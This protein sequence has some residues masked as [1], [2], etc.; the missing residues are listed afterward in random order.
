MPKYERVIDTD[1]LVVGGGS[2]GCL[3][4]IRAKE[5][6]PGL[7][8]TV[9]EKGDLMYSGCIARG[10]DALNI[11]A[12]PG[13]TTPELYVES[14]TIACEGVVDEPPSYVMA[15]RSWGLLKK[16][17]SWGVYFPKRNGRYETLKVH[18]KGE[19]LV[20]MKEPDLKVIIAKRVY[21]LGCR[22][23]NR[24]MAIELLMDGDRVAG[25]LGYNVRT[26]EL[27]ICRAK[28][29]ILCSGGLARFSLPT[30]GYLY[31]VYDFPHNTGDGWV[32]AY[33]AGAELTGLEHTTCYCIIKD[34]SA[35]L[36]YITLT[37]GAVVLNGFGEQIEGGHI[38]IKS[39]VQEY[40]EDRGPLFIRMSHLPEEKIREIEDILF[41]T[42]RPVMERFFRGRGIDFRHSDIELFN[43]EHFL[44]SGHGLAGLVVDAHGATNVRGLY[45]A[46]DVACVAKGHL[47]GAFTFGEITA[48]AAAELCAAEPQADLPE[49]QVAAARAK[50]ARI[51]DMN[52]PIP[53]QEFEYKVRR[54][55]TNY[56]IPP[57]NETK[58]QLGLAWME[59]FRGQLPQLVHV[60]DPH[61]ASKIYEI[62]SI[63]ETA[64]LSARA[65]LARRESRWG[66]WHYRTDYPEKDDD[67][68][69]RH[70][71]LTARPDSKEPAVSFREV[72]K[73][74]P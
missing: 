71:V 61:W 11:V 31:G 33:R 23:V 57:K 36:L 4:A 47:T 50:L 17:E 12:I 46:G 41:T 29:V 8:V 10:M 70:V 44:C 67:Q 27:I 7:D 58:L 40:V 56:L 3:A 13:F 35:P 5:V 55:I 20:T 26:G 62:E 53:P 42:E 74:H 43:T 34:I 49:N 45:A 19:F 65:S 63:I 66:F 51:F 48:E 72:E 6:D 24:T 39:L 15:Q 28:A 21:D 32:M 38:S 60:R 25:A 52:G 30:S 69:Q 16:L 73:L 1:I 2:A 59:R 64:S 54:L 37:R 68:W 18:P 22:V 14:N 9:F